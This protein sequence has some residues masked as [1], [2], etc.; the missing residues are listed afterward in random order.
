MKLVNKMKQI[1]VVKEIEHMKKK[2]YDY[3]EKYGLNNIKTVDIS[4]RIDKMLVKVYK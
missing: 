2:M 4:Q 3:I 1:R